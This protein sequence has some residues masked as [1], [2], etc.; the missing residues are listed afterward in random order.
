MQKNKLPK[1]NQGQV[2]IIVLLVSAVLLTLGLSASKKTVTDVK[3]DT[4]EELLKSA[5]N[6]AE[7]GINKYLSNKETTYTDNNGGSAVV[8]ANDIGGEQSLSSEGKV[9]A[10][11]NQVF[12][13]VDHNTTNGTIGSQYYSSQ[14]PTITL[15][16][17]G[18]N[19]YSGAIKIDYF[20]IDPATGA[21]KVARTGCNYNAASPVVTGFSN[22]KTNCQTISLTGRSL[23]VSITPINGDTNITISGN[24]NFPIQGQTIT[25]VGTVNADIRTQIKT[26]YTYNIPSF[27]FEAITAKNIVTN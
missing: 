24:G 2:A 13:L 10:N 17:N 14:N 15:T 11:T 6:T 19:S 16:V 7:S 21:Y 1:H 4:D 22:D 5:F 26:R 9:A 25:S 20:Y 18:D 27:M 3:V 12:W 8:T 23:L